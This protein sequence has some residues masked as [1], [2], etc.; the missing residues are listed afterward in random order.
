[1]PKFHLNVFDQAIAI[2]EE[3][4]DHPTLDS[5]KA[6]AVAGARELIAARVLAGKPIYTDHRIDITDADGQ[7][8][9]TVFFGDILEIRP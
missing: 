8:L 5:A 7:A 1:V 2:D 4:S 6:S 3:G 9:H